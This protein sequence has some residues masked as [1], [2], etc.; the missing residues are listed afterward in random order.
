MLKKQLRDAY[1]EI[2]GDFIETTDNL[3]IA[4]ELVVAT[5]AQ[6]KYD[7]LTILKRAFDKAPNYND[8]QEDEKTRDEIIEGFKIIFSYF[9]PE[10][11][12]VTENFVIFDNIMDDIPLEKLDILAVESMMVDHLV[13][14]NY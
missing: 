14:R 7:F 11:V 4:K 12:K 9:D 2:S 1:S 13:H 8:E 3:E 5:R 6:V 10:A